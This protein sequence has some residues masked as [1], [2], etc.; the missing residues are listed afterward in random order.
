MARFRGEVAGG[1]G[2]A[3]RLGHAT[4]GL[5]TKTQS[6]SGDVIVEMFDVDGADHCRIKIANHADGC[7]AVTLYNGPIG[8]ALD[9][10][11]HA[12]I[13]QTTIAAFAP[14]LL[15]A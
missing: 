4:K 2:V 13:V 10:N 15:V 14:H 8:D 12:V 11:K 3:S 6:W 9:K 1:R 7:T 5:Y